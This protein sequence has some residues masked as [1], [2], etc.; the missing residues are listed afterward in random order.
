MEKISEFS[1]VKEEEDRGVAMSYGSAPSRETED[2]GS[3]PSF[4]LDTVVTSVFLSLWNTLILLSGLQ[5]LTS[6]HCCLEDL[7]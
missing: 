7:R 3:C 6:E 1:E 2:L 5:G 4:T